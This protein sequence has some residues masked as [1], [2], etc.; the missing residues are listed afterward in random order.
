MER[1]GIVIRKDF[2]EVPPRVQYSLT[3]F[4]VVLADAL[5]PLCEWGPNT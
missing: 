5:R 2:R 1:D 4:G 3:S